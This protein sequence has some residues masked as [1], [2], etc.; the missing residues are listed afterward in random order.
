MLQKTVL[1]VI[2]II[3]TVSIIIDWINTQ[4]KIN[5]TFYKIKHLNALYPIEE[6]QQLSN[7]SHADANR[8][9]YLEPYAQRIKDFQV[10]SHFRDSISWRLIIDKEDFSSFSIWLQKMPDYNNDEKLYEIKNKLVYHECLE[11]LTSKVGFYRFGCFSSQASIFK[12]IENSLSL[13]Y[14]GSNKVIE[15]ISI[16]NQYNIQESRNGVITIPLADTLDIAL[17][18]YRNG[19]YYL[20]QHSDRLLQR[21]VI[22]ISNIEDGEI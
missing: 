15:W 14:N 17:K 5:D 9:K 1:I 20:P 18:V 19:T 13:T 11:Y 4:T 10:P 8:R 3:L 12:D 22:D 2:G 7:V 16:D 21:H 6:L